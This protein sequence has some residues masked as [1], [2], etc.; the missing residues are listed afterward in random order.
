M[1]KTPLKSEECCS[2]EFVE[3]YDI[4]KDAN[5]REVEQS[6]VCHEFN[7]VA[8]RIDVLEKENEEL[9]KKLKPAKEKNE[10]KFPLT[11][12]E[13]PIPGLAAHDA[14]GKEVGTLPLVHIANALKRDKAS[15]LARVANMIGIKGGVE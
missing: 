10:M 6:D 15:L 8:E 7:A 12:Y 4:I 9:K 5:G 14:D 13:G 11:P 2:E 1:L 3:Y